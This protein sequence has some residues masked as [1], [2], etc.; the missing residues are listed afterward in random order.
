MNDTS[1]SNSGAYLITLVAAPGLEETLVDWLL[2]HE[3]S[4]GFTGDTVNGHS[5]QQQGL[6]L[7]E[8]VAGRRR[9]VRFDMHVPQ[10]ELAALLE[11]LKL[12]FA[13]TGL[14]YWIVPVVESGR[15]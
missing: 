2:A 12:D 1:D 9:Q 10:V 8:Q 11:R 5:S 15:L 6:K 3:S 14:H 7:E 13:G 4:Y